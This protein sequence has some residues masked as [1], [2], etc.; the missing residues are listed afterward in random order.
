MRTLL[1]DQTTWDLCL[2]ASGNIAVA[3][4]PY[5]LAQDVAS[6]IRLFAGEAWYDTSLGIP[7]FEQI[8]G[9]APP[10]S[11]IKEQFTRTALTVPGVVA[12]VC[13]LDSIAGRQLT[14]QVRVTDTAGTV[15]TIAFAGGSTSIGG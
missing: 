14:G 13:T 6:A 4:D 15:L 5:A 11:L 1:L 3:A 12:A 2:D 8:L 10:V 7:Y 9:H